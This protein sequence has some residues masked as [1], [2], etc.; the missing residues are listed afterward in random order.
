VE[1]A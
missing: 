1:K